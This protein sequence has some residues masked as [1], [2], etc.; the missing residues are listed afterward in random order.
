MEKHTCE[1]KFKEY[2]YLNEEESMKA[3]NRILDDMLDSVSPDPNEVIGYITMEAS[4]GKVANFPVVLRF[5]TVGDNTYP[6]Y[7]VA[8]AYLNEEDEEPLD[9]RFD[10]V[11]ESVGDVDIMATATVIPEEDGREKYFLD[12]E[13]GYMTTDHDLK[14]DNTVVSYLR[15]RNQN[16]KQLYQIL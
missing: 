10:Q 12:Y 2:T 13:Y 1:M 7:E 9:E 14:E 5:T 6:Q 16:T 8:G 11:Q 3:I 4:N 15:I